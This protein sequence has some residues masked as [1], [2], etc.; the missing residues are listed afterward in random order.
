MNTLVKRCES[1][2]P[3]ARVTDELLHEW[4]EG[5][6][7]LAQ[8]LLPNTSPYKDKPLPIVPTLLPCE[9]AVY[10]RF[11][12][13]WPDN[14]GDSVNLYVTNDW[15]FYLMLLRT[16]LDPVVSNE[17]E[18]VF[19]DGS[20]VKVGVINDVLQPFIALPESYSMVRH[21]SLMLLIGT[22]WLDSPSR[23]KWFQLYGDCSRLLKEQYRLVSDTKALLGDIEA[24]GLRIFKQYGYKTLSD[25]G[26]EELISDTALLKELIDYIQA[27]CFGIAVLFEQYSLSSDKEKWLE[28]QLTTK[29]TKQDYLYEEFDAYIRT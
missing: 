8:Q 26:I 4:V 12:G 25:E 24:K 7:P 13:G 1:M 17:L 2:K 10:G 3:Y 20:R 21:H 29:V 15:S 9:D 5:A 19:F 16:A 28:S 14:T 11:M 23:D 6:K 18:S 27:T 22:L